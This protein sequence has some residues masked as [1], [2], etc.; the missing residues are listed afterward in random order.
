MR[1]RTIDQAITEIRESDPN[2]ALTWSGLRKLVLTKKI[3]HTQIGAKR[4][5]D[6]DQ[7]EAYLCGEEA[8][9]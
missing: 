9:Q 2:T 6:L 8:E 3:P 5:I 4:L 7:L 1:L